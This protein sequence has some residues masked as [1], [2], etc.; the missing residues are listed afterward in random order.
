MTNKG[1]AP[2]KEINFEALD[3]LINIQCTGEE[4]ASVLGVDYD[5]LN[6]RIKD[7]GYDGFSDYFDKKRGKGKAS[8][9]RLQW[10]TAEEGNPT[11][12]IWL[13]K[14]WLQQTDKQEITGKDGK[15]LL[16]ENAYTEQ[17]LIEEAKS[18]GLVF[19]DDPPFTD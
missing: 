14:Q 9:R 16:P 7:K 19:S 5:T 15:D 3:N 2:I 4:C 6:A 18:R 1:G 8:L 11:M 17:E 13:G 10:K 12:L